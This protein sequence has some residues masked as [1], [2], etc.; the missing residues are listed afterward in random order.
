MLRGPWPP[1]GFAYTEDGDGLIVD[2]ER[3]AVVRDVF[4]MIGGEGL[5]MGETQRR[6]N[7]DGV[8]S[9]MAEDRRRWKEKNSGKWSV[10]TIR[11]MVAEPPVPAAHR[12]G[13]RR[14]RDGRP[15]GRPLPRPGGAVR[16]LEVGPG[17]RADLAR[18]RGAAEGDGRRGQGA[19]RA[20]RTA[21]PLDHRPPLL[22]ALRRDRPV[23]R[24]RHR[25][26]PEG[27]P[28]AQRQDRRLVLVSPEVEQ[29]REGL[30]ARDRCTARPSSRRRS[31]ARSTA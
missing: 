29:R 16:P 5:T 6:L 7:R 20:G 1:Y 30:H 11:K 21:S 10:C 12:R 4:R 3:M 17:V 13:G 22:A 26:L 8:P 18:G 23:R 9:P 28:A 14:L 24:V 2:P 15:G 25:A 31:G 27:A 19:D